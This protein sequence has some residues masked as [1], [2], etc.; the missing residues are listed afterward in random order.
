LREVEGVVESALAAEDAARLPEASAP[1]PWATVLDAVVWFHR[2]APGAA[3]RLPGAL[4]GRRALPLTVGALIRYRET[5]VGPYREVLASPSLL[6]GSRGPEACVPFIAVDSAASVHGG[7]ENWALPKTLARFEWPDEPRGGFELD[8]EGRGWSVHA[9]VRARPRRL[10]F[11]A[12]SRN[13]QV[14]PAGAEIVFDSRWRG[15]ARVASVELETRG[16]TLP[17]WLRSGRHPALV[18]DG[19]TLHVGAARPG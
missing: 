9:S 11:A 3:D 17:G 18:L 6:L 10:P 8:A 4:R 1:A 16:P 15:R 19:A 13:R 7:R 2:A 12:I 5:P 14:T